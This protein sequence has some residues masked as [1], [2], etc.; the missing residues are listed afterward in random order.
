VGETIVHKDAPRQGEHLCLVL[1]A[2][3]WGRI[4][5]SVAVALELRTVVMSD[6]VTLFLPQSL[7]GDE[8]VPIHV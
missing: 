3:E 2:A 7:V 6:Q 5:E 8:L 1:K 4:D